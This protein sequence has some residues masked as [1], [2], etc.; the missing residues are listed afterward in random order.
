[1]A[2]ARRGDNPRGRAPFA[3][4]RQPRRRGVPVPAHQG[5]GSGRSLASGTGTQGGH[6]SATCLRA[7]RPRDTDGRAAPDLE[8]WNRKEQA[9]RGGKQRQQESG[10]NKKP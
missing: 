4:R 3:L 9:A 5:R 10:M 6:T 1:M 2:S 8:G 7:G